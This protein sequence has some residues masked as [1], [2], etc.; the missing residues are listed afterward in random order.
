MH[1]CTLLRL[2]CMDS[3]GCNS[4]MKT[5][6]YCIKVVFSYQKMNAEFNNGTFWHRA[7]LVVFLLTTLVLLTASCLG[8]IFIPHCPSTY[9][10]YIHT[11]YMYWD[12]TSK[13]KCELSVQRLYIAASFVRKEPN[14]GDSHPLTFPLGQ[15]SSNMEDYQ[16]ANDSVKNLAHTCTLFYQAPGIPHSDLNP[17][18]PPRHQAHPALRTEQCWWQNGLLIQQAFGWN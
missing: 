11:F 6:L 2:K 14:Y 17:T 8:Y 12:F 3:A 7:M 4:R 15:C 13:P 16:T 10:T 5:R 9:I 1:D 18:A